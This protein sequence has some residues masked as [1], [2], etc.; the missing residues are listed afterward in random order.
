MSNNMKVIME[1]W[2]RN[3]LLKENESVQLALDLASSIRNARQAY[4]QFN[5]NAMTIGD[6]ID[7]FSAASVD[8]MVERHS[9]VK[10]IIKI[11]LDSIKLMNDNIG[12]EDEEGVVTTKED[13][14]ELVEIVENLVQFFQDLSDKISEVE[15]DASSG[16]FAA[17]FKKATTGLSQAVLSFPI[18]AIKSLMENKI[19]IGVAQKLGFNAALQS[20]AEIIPFGGTALKAVKSLQ[21]LSGWVGED[22]D[23]AKAANAENPEE[24]YKM[25]MAAAV[26]VDDSKEDLMGPLSVL[27]IDDEYQTILDKKVLAEF[28]K[29]WLDA[30]K[31]MDRNTR[32]DKL[33]SQDFLERFVKT[34]YKVSIN[35]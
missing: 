6:M 21:T 25:M 31:S 11:L 32:L 22:S 8:A 33:A 12:I 28:I 29:K 23:V 5:P 24:A 17:L 2:R 10:A 15:S 9:A 4:N 35:T 18:D 26:T 13:I 20:A 19:F 3:V 34:K 14:D 7:L 27:D 16:L 30:L 1:S